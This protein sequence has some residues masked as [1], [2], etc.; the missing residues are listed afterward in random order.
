MQNVKSNI[1]QVS[2]LNLLKYGQVNIVTTKADEEILKT[3]IY[4]DGDVLTSMNRNSRLNEEVVHA[5]KKSIVKANNLLSRHLTLFKA[6]F[7]LPLMFVASGI[8]ALAM[9]SGEE[10][11]DLV[12]SELFSVGCL[13]LLTGALW[14]LQSAL[15]Y[16]FKRRILH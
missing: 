1:E 14:C 12:F 2:L 6:R 3:S 10:I 13:T 9:R 15:I 5:H 8:S 11:A 7:I 4:Y 16:Y